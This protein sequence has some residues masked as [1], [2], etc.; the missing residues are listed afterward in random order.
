MN[1]RVFS[2][3]ALER[4]LLRELPRGEAT[5]IERAAAADPRVRS[6]LVALEASNRDILARY[7]APRF[8]ARLLDRLKEEEATTP[9]WKRWAVAASAAAAVVLAVVL[10]GPRLVQP[11]RTPLAVPGGPENLVKGEAGVDLTR[12]RLLVYRKTGDRAEILED[13]A[14]VGA[15]AL[16]Q[17]AYVSSSA[18]Y[19]TILSIDGRGEV[20]RH[21]PAEAGGSTLLALHKRVLLPS[22]LELDDAPGFERFFLV[23]SEAPVEVEAVLAEA[24]VLAKDLV[25]ARRG[26]LD[27]PAG[28]DQASVM[29]L[30]REGAR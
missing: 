28:L 21:F 23:T 30:K 3:L 16:L 8:K 13:G 17:L 1:D 10:I 2:E 6:A 14:E 26:E 27:L 4:Y 24:A 11:T 19:G 12:T 25:K 29:I 20:T 5:E 7:P 22:A 15:G 9:S 18:A